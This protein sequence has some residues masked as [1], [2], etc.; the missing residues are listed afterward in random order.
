[1]GREYVPGGVAVQMSKR[2]CSS[3]LSAAAIQET[4]DSMTLCLP[5]W[6]VLWSYLNSAGL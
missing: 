4:G 2:R 1:M 6:C 5:G 3:V